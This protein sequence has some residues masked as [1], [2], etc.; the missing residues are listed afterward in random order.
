MKYI[1]KKKDNLLEGPWKKRTSF[2]VRA[3]RDSEAYSPSSRKDQWMGYGAMASVMM[4]LCGAL[5]FHLNQKEDSGSGRYLSSVEYA[6][7][8]DVKILE[9]LNSGKR[10]L[11]SINESS[12]EEKE[13]LEYTTLQNYYVSFD[14]QGFLS[15][16]QLKPGKSPIHLKDPSS[17]VDKHK[18]FF[19]PYKSMSR[20][21]EKTESNT[22]VYVLQ[23]SDHLKLVFNLNDE[24]QL[25]SFTLKR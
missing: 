5:T 10:E 24:N 15:E 22:F 6:P 8:Q 14:V 13:H 9:E 23:G 16:I 11:S 21:K 12:L 2:Q 19:P 25:V 4:V 18:A 3:S 17:F 20:L 1:K 7:E